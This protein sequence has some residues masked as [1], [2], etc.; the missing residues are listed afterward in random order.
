[1]SPRDRT[2]IASLAPF[3]LGHAKPHHFLE[4]A[5]VAWENRNNLAYAWRILRH[6]VCDG[7]SLGPK[8]LADDTLDGIHLCLSRLKL[9]RLNTM[10]G[11]DTAV[12]SDVG[13]LRRLSGEELRNLG[14]LPHPMVRKKGD[15]GFRRI[16]WEEALDI[17]AGYL[18]Q[19]PPDRIAFYNTSR[20]ITNE[21]Y[22]VAQK[23][24]R[25]LGTN[26]ID[27]AARLCHAA[28]TTAL[29]KTIGV[30]ASTCSYSDWIGA[31]LVVLFG[32]DLANNQ[33]VSLKYLY[34]AKQKGTRVVVV[35]PYREPGLERY[36]IPSVTK[37]AL[38]GTR[39]A[40]DFF[41]VSVGGDVAFSNGVMK[42]LIEQGGLD[43]AFIRDHTSGFDEL[44]E[45]LAGQ[46]WPYL[47]AGAGV[48]EDEMLRFARLYANAKTAVFVWS[49]G[50]TQHRF[51]VQ[52]VQAVVN[53]AL[54]RG[55]IG[56]PQCGLVPI[57]GHSG[58][59]GAAEVGSGPSS[60][61]G[62][63]A[64]NPDN[65]RRFSKLWGF[66]VP[67]EPGLS[68]P[69]M[70]DAAHR[71]DLD[72][73][74]IMG[75]NFLETLPDPLYVKK[76]LERV[77]LRVHQDLIVNSS[78]LLDPL[79]LVLLLPA[80]TRYEQKGGG[81]ATNTERRIRFSPEIP[82]PR[83]GEA[84]S[85]W[86][87]LMQVGERALGPDKASLVHFADAQAIRDEMERVIPMYKGI[88]HLRKE[89][90][91]V[92]YGGSTLLKD[93]NCPTADGRAHFTPLEPPDT[94][95]PKG[96]FYLATRRGRQFN[97]I[98]WGQTDP[99]TGSRRREEIFIAPEDASRLGIEAGDRL[100]LRSKVGEFEGVAKLSPVRPKTLQAFW[101]E[102]NV[103]IP[104]RVDPA[105]GE[106]DYNVTVSLEKLV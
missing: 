35:N 75:G 72:V 65:A 90:D 40:D 20:G 51:G 45:A 26:N 82:G 57:R 47:E 92:Q 76:A 89:G 74:Y 32:A 18:R 1:M 38:F 69:S 84:R 17:A 78:M 60:Y 46:V 86:E 43:E 100:R 87:I 98:L 99:L 31:D 19:A 6:G 106:P 96:Q 27:N 34:Y 95:L 58:V 16:G 105:S 79:E 103:L 50:L 22:Y 42:H 52:N 4:M 12:L 102:A 66:E 77:P 68:A 81:T 101:P 13:A 71:R 29:K 62:G 54:A 5:K 44:K 33:P 10:T 11:L 21:V 49:M 85:E 36:W 53:L 48:G 55:M 28:S 3:G 14:R 56:R 23:L 88:A 24:V 25:L 83:I 61:P 7:C 8:G 37:S 97:S 2:F 41:Q 104:R 93:G 80:Q 15:A 9:L 94:A 59:Q 67:A 91:A 70:V 63:F 30:G 39:L 73:F 64:V